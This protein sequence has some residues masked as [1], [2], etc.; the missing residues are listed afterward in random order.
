MRGILL[1]VNYDGQY[2]FYTTTPYCAKLKFYDLDTKEI[3]IMDD[4]YD[5]EPYFLIIGDVPV[6]IQ[7]H[8]WYAGKKIVKKYDPLDD[9]SYEFTR[10]IAKNPL[11]VSGTQNSMSQMIEHAWEN[12]IPYTVNY[13][14]DTQLIPG[15]CYDENLE[16]VELPID[17]EILAQINENIDDEADAFKDWVDAYCEWLL[18][19]ISFIPRVAFDTEVE[20]ELQRGRYVIP[21]V[22]TCKTR[23]LTYSIVGNEGTDI[24]KEVKEEDELTTIIDLLNQLD[25]Y[26]MVVTYNGDK[27]DLKYLYNRAMKLGAKRNQLPLRIDNDGY[28]HFRHAVHIDLPPFFRLPIIKT[29]AFSKA[30]TRVSLEAVSQA[31]LK[32]GKIKHPGLVKDM[33][34]KER[35]KY[36]RQDAKLTLELTTFN[37]EM[38]FR[39]IMLIMRIEKVDLFFVTRKSISTWSYAKY[40]WIH[41][42]LDWLIPRKEDLIAKAQVRT[43]DD[44]IVGRYRGGMIMEPKPGVF[45]DAVTMDYTSLYPYLIKE[46]NISYET[47]ECGHDECKDKL[48]TGYQICK[49]KV[50]MLAIHLGMLLLLRKDYFKPAAKQNKDLKPIEQTLKIL[51]NADAGVFGS[52]NFAMSCPIVSDATTGEAR[53][54]IKSLR[55]ELLHPQYENPKYSLRQ[56]H[57]NASDTIYMHT[58]SC[59]LENNNEII[60]E[61][62]EYFAKHKL[63]MELDEEDTFI[64]I[65]LSHRKAN[66]FGLTDKGEIIVKGLRGKKSDTCD[67]FRRLFMATMEQFATVENKDDLEFVKTQFIDRLKNFRKRLKQQVI[68]LEDLAFHVTLQ[69]H[70][71]KYKSKTGH[72]IVAAEVLISTTGEQIGK[73][74]VVHFVKTKGKGALPVS[75]ATPD[76]INT[77]KYLDLLESMVLPITEP[78]NIDLAPIM[79]GNKTLDDFWKV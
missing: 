13:I 49:K 76:D 39:L 34:P 45:W 25:E 55:D 75:L 20:E 62:G 63:G 57:D 30:Y 79:T 53:D 18:S 72:H 23:F 66:Y 68:P 8:V 33:L 56:L 59:I 58:D 15:M 74:D 26:P 1:E 69:K 51:M 14:A 36:C 40:V 42:Q 31:L 24:T 52:E 27:F 48:T 35:K 54:A 5:H 73:G 17:E 11:G 6:K 29:Y 70:L 67:A 46:R 9:T 71:D 10:I 2:P 65:A 32:K 41:R 28:A 12:H 37:N 16:P 64:F 38:V 4:P 21:N 19:E 7:K 78:F 60:K 61:H 22:N 44:A 43:G 3:V 50:G 77:Q 47:L